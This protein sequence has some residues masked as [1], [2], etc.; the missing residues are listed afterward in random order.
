[1]NGH[2]YEYKC[3]R[4]LRRKGFHH[5]EVTRKSGD[6]GV[7]IIAYKGFSKYAVQCKYYSYPVGNKAVQEVYAGGKYY[8]C[9]RCIVMTNSTFTKAAISAAN[10]LDVKLW[11]NCSMIKSSSLIFEAMRSMSI[12]T[13]IFGCYLLHDIPPFSSATYMQHYRELILTLAGLL[14]WLGWGS[15]GISSI[16]GLLY[17][18]LG[19]TMNEGSIPVISVNGLNLVFLIPA[20]IYFIHVYLLK[21]K[22]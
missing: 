20:L 12:L 22:P 19:F 15:W 8:D 7:D 3:A 13:F 6:Q 2:K 18:F 17:L 11:D 4:M 5:V 21:P 1:M 16:T 9:D 14:G 10:K